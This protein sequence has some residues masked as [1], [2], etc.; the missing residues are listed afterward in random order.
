MVTLNSHNFVRIIAQIC[1]FDAQPIFNAIACA[2]FG[3]RVFI[4]PQTVAI[5]RQLS[6]YRQLII[7]AVALWKYYEY[8]NV[9]NDDIGILLKRQK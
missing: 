5:S 4:N 2:P 3:E 7:Y 9:T 8:S 1:A 6:V